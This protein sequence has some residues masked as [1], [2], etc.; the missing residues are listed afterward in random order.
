MSAELDWRILLKGIAAMLEG[1]TSFLEGMT[2]AEEL[3]LPMRILNDASIVSK[4]FSQVFKQVT[5]EDFLSIMSAVYTIGKLSGVNIQ[6]MT[7]TERS[8]LIAEVRETVTTFN[9]ITGGNKL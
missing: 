3:G 7:L 6:T 2:K 5:K 9:Q 1:Y 8:Q 4:A